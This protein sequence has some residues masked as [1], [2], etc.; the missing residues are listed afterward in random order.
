MISADNIGSLVCQVADSF[1]WVGRHPHEPAVRKFKA[2]SSKL[3]RVGL[4]GGA[5]ILPSAF[6][7]LP[8]RFLGR[9][10]LALL[11]AC[12]P[13]CAALGLMNGFPLCAEDW[14]QF[15][16][17][18]RDGTSTETNILDRLPPA[19]PPTVWSAEIGTGYSAPSVREGRLVLFHRLGNEEVVQSYESRTGQAGWRYAYP[20]Q[21][22]DPYGYNNGPRASPLLTTNRCYTFGAEGRL[23][24]LEL[25][26]GRLVWS[27][28]TAR[29]WKVPPA[30]F[31]TGS[32]PLLE[33]GRLIVM[34]GG[35]PDAGMVALSPETGRT[36]WESV[37]RETWDGALT[38]GWRAERPYAWTGEEMLASYS[39][40][41]AVS[42]HGQRHLLCLMRQG[43]VSLDPTNGAIRFQR[44]FQAQVGESVNALVPVVVGDA[45]L[46]S[47]AYYR[48]GAVLLR[49]LPDGRSFE[50]VWRFPKHPMDQVDRDPDTGRWKPLPL[51]VHWS[52]PVVKDGHVYAFSGRNEPD[53]TLRCVELATGR[54]KWSRDER[55]QHTRDQAQPPV[56]GRGSMILAGD[57]LI[58]LGEGGLLGLFRAS[59]ER[60]TELGRWQVPPLHYP[61]WAAPVLADGLLYLRSENRLVCLNLGRP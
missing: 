1:T 19:G 29:E 32:S 35:Q 33:D 15:L 36:V 7:I 31:G 54:V 48:S 2:Q 28:E 41:I 55:W 38:L 37:G 60:A 59:R 24:C 40:P 34:V 12:V 25:G 27:R 50:E 39:S 30:F 13:W 23:T 11:R 22:E 42:I 52:T 26:T 53:A 58:A 3:K 9:G 10:F 17:P 44:W 4:G 16:G 5:K 45:I 14:P 8:F 20:S 61:C 21:F 43:L 57:K 47:S 6:F 56:F 18:R 46:I 51:E 49:A